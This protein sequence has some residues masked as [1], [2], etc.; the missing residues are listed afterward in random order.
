MR[1]AV[2]DGQRSSRLESPLLE[3]PVRVEPGNRRYVPPRAVRSEL[4]SQDVVREVD[5]EDLRQATAQSRIGDRDD[6]LD[7]AVEVA[8]HEVGRAEEVLRLAAVAEAKDARMLEEVTDD[9]PHSDALRKARDA[10]TQRAHAADQE[11][12]LG[13]RLR[14]GVQR[15]DDLGVDQVVDLE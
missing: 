13:A 9:G 2:D 14:C 7:A 4:P 3:A 11:V 6:R 8:R 10:R 12:D 1:H 15:V 5:L